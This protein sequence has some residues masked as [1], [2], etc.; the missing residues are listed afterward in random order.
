[1][2]KGTASIPWDALNRIPP[3]KTAAKTPPMPL[4]EKAHPSFA[5]TIPQAHKNPPMPQYGKA[6]PSFGAIIPQAHKNP[7]NKY[8]NERARHKH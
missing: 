4:C 3:Q 2:W 5:A 6:H 7:E 1:M 8:M